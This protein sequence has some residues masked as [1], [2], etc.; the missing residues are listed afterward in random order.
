M[1]SN[2]YLSEISYPVFLLGKTKPEID[3][4]VMYY[5]F[6]KEVDGVVQ[7]LLR[8]IDDKSLPQ[9]TLA[10]R[11]MQLVNSGEKVQKIGLAIFFLGDLIK[12]GTKHTWFIDSKGKLFNYRKDTRAKLKCYR[13]SKLIR[14]PTGGAIVEVQGVPTRFKALYPPANG[15]QYVGLLHYGKSLV[16]YGFY[17]QQYDE[18]WR[19]V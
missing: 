10:L 14:M 18:T 12:L 8:I 1:E 19:M 3:N 2:T 4:K 7:P 5:Y 15:E 9:E 13:I 11:R 6:E 16:L 17:D